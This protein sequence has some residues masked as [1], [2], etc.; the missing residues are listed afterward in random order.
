MC[1]NLVHHFGVAGEPT[2]AY[3]FARFVEEFEATHARHAA[4]S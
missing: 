3:L 2:R 4:D 1:R